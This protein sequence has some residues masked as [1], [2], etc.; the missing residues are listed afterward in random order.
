MA[1]LRA[2]V[3]QPH[4]DWLR[5]G[6]SRSRVSSPGRSRI[7][8]SPYRPDRLRRPPGLLLNSYSKGNGGFST[9]VKR[10]AGEADHS[11]PTSAAVKKTWVNTLTLPNVL[12]ELYLIKHGDNFTFTL[13]LDYECSVILLNYSY[14]CPEFHTSTDRTLELVSYNIRS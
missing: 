3:A 1:T 4:S 9:G 14:C 11:H 6:R 7:L 2:V 13:S 10:P 8:T 12:M 5:A